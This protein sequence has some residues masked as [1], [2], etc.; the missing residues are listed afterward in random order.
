MS[1]D[2][3]QG[4]SWGGES[5]GGSESADGCKQQA[6]GQCVGPAVQEAEMMLPA[7]DTTANGD[8]F[9]VPILTCNS[10]FFQDEGCRRQRGCEDGARPGSSHPS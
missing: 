5:R 6:G 4:Y 2:S 10:F 3:G 9:A 1:V 7:F 8:D